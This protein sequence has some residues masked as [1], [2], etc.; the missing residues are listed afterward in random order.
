M[1]SR[2]QLTDAQR[3]IQKHMDAAMDT[4]IKYTAPEVPKIENYT[5]Q[6]LVEEAGRI[7]KAKG[8]VEKVE[9]ILKERLRSMREGKNEIR[10]DNFTL[11]I[12]SQPR[13]ALNQGAAKDFF[14][15]LA[16]FEPERLLKWI[17]ENAPD[18]VKVEDN[19]LNIYQSMMTSTD[20]ETM[21]FSE[22]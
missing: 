19:E 12:T 3:R 20:V 8:A 17:L 14:E 9:K 6:G 22:N 15:R 1:A 18:S 10:S 5:P 4:V 2:P 11:K 13:T 7:N 16:A 21:R